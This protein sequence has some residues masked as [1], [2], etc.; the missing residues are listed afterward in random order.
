MKSEEA[1][2]IVE[3]FYE[4]SV[5]SEE[6]EFLLTEA[7]D[8]LITEE[9]NPEYMMWLG[10][11][12]YEKKLFDLALKYYEMARTY[13]YDPAY[14]CLGYIWYYGRT[15]EKDYAKAFEYYSKM[16]EK[17]DP[18]ASYKVADMYKNGYHVEKDLKKYEEIIEELYRDRAPE[19]RYYIVLRTRPC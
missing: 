3:Q 13:D 17:G 1:R 5:H 7:L 4:K 11:F 16:M 19:F 12:Y 18:V 9:Q 10:G 6:E 15:G 8:L 14:L 2:E